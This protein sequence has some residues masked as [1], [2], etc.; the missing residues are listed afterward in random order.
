[1]PLPAVFSP[2]S[3]GGGDRKEM[4]SPRQQRAL[5]ALLKAPDKRTAARLANI[6][7]RTLRTY[8]SDPD[9][10]AEYQ[11]LQGE[12][13]ADAAQR[14]RQSM[15][16]AMDA[17]RAVMDDENQNGQTRVQAARSILE[18]SLKLDERENILKRLDELEATM[19]DE[20]GQ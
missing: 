9:F 11:R 17:L 6:G 16:G 13:I 7:E 18:Y 4:L 15:T 5:Q 10:A 12:Q 1:M 14:G 2:E 8:L 19:G 20:H 3:G